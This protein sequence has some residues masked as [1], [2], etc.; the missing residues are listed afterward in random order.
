MRVIEQLGVAMARI[1]ALKQNNQAHEALKEIEQACEKYIG[2]DPRVI[3]A[4]SGEALLGLMSMGGKF[5]PRRAVLLGELLREEGELYGM[6]SM[7]ERS[8][9]GYTR[10]LWLFL[11]SMNQD[12]ALRTPDNIEDTRFVLGKLARY[13]LSPE[14]KSRLFCYYEWTGEFDKAENMLFD[15]L[16]RDRHTWGGK[17]ME[18]YKRL[19]AKSD[20]ELARGGLPREELELGMKELGAESEE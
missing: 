8:Y 12:P 19:G 16:D 13:E 4:A 18:F 10:S 6:E 1:V 14:L 15:L 5:D 3:E 20:S 11:E 9:W 17:G 7:A 2:L